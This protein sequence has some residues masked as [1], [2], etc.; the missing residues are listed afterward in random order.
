MEK[1]LLV[2]ELQKNNKKEL[3]NEKIIKKKE[4]NYMSNGKD[5][6]ILLIL[7]LIKKILENGQYFTS[8]RSPGRNIKVE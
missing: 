2:E 3:T 8:Y 7:G 1:K 6:T 5:M 4:I